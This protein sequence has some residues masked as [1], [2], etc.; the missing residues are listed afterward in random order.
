MKRRSIILSDD[1]F[2]SFSQ[3]DNLNTKA[4]KSKD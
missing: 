4:R 2:S 3:L 1:S